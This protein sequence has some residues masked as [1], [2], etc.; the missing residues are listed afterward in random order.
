MVARVSP[1]RSGVEKPTIPVSRTTGTIGRSRRKRCGTSLC[2]PPSA[3]LQI[4]RMLAA[5]E[6]SVVEPS[7]VER[8]VMV[9]KYDDLREPSSN[10]LLTRWNASCLKWGRHS[11][12]AEATG[13]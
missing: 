13:Q 12:A 10:R 1:G 5:V 3:R 11:S 2:K 7:F 4:S 9:P 8:S 6:P